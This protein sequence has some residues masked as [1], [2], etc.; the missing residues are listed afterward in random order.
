MR[1]MGSAR[2]PEF[3]AVSPVLKCKHGSKYLGVTLALY[4]TT[5]VVLHQTSFKSEA[6]TEIADDR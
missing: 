2:V 3:G 4:V 6:E 1:G 5:S